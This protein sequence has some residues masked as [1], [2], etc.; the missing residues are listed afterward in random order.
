MLGPTI[1]PMVRELG[2]PSIQL[3][4]T[5]RLFWDVHQFFADMIA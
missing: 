2:K 5:D 1:D 3:R 4:S